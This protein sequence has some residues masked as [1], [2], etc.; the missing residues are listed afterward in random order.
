MQL[1]TDRTSWIFCSRKAHEGITPSELLLKE[2][3]NA[4]KSRVIGYAAYVH[5]PKEKRPWKLAQRGKLSILLR[6]QGGMYRNW[7]T[8]LKAIRESNMWKL[9]E[10]KLPSKEVSD[11]SLYSSKHGENESDQGNIYEIISKID[12]EEKSTTKDL[13]SATGLLSTSR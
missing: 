5:K 10:N 2:R 11:L 4:S 1:Y 7:E 9:E 8:E 6:H 12:D 13:R 3:S